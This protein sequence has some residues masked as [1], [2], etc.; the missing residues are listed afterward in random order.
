MSSILLKTRNHIFFVCNSLLIKVTIFDSQSCRFQINV[1]C[2]L[3]AAESLAVN[4]S[5][6][7]LRLLL[8]VLM[9]I[10]L[11]LLWITYFRLFVPSQRTRNDLQHQ[12]KEKKSSKLIHIFIIIF[13]YKVCCCLLVKISPIKFSTL[14]KL[15]RFRLV[16]GFYISNTQP[17]DASLR[18]S[19]I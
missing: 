6:R 10:R 8:Q 17:L 1:S 12:D 3:L 16:S 2:C 14:G 15:K 13:L 7:W 11:Q 9:K 5:V 19:L 4:A 18:Q